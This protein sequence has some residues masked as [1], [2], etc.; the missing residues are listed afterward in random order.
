MTIIII[1]IKIP[2]NR[3]TKLNLIAWLNKSWLTMKGWSSKSKEKIQEEW[4]L[5]NN[6]NSSKMEVLKAACNKYANKLIKSILKW[7]GINQSLNLKDLQRQV[8][9]LF[10][11]PHPYVEG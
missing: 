7:I 2:F 8:N 9:C 10:P 1:Q 3:D 11:T 5:N 4:Y 6:N